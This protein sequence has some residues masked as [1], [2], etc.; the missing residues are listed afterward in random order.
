MC[1]KIYWSDA[2]GMRK[3]EGKWKHQLIKVSKNYSNDII[4]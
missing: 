2:E 4:E 1:N 3:L